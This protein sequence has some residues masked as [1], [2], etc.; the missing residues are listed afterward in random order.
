[1]VLLFVV[2]LDPLVLNLELLGLEKFLEWHLHGI[3]AS[4]VPTSMVSNSQFSRALMISR[5]A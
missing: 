4:D 1:M 3:A 5:V 2:K